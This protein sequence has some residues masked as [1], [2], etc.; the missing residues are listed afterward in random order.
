VS[1]ATALNALFYLLT[2]LVEFEAGVSA[3]APNLALT[4]ES[5]NSSVVG[6]LLL[7]RG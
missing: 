7:T 1:D 5:L 3:S 2:Y 4:E 6:H